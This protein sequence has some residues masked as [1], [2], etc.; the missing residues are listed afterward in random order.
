MSGCN[1][2]GAGAGGFRGAR[3]ALSWGRLPSGSAATAR[4][5][6]SVGHRNTAHSPPHARRSAAAAA[7]G[8]IQR[9]GSGQRAG[10]RGQGAAAG[11]AGAPRYI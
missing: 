4:P 8:G 3:L 11:G 1:Q 9:L 5:S 6:G 7:A 10:G 2:A